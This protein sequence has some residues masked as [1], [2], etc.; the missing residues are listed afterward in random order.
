MAGMRQRSGRWPR[1]RL[2]TTASLVVLLGWAAAACAGDGDGDDTAAGG[3]DTGGGS[4]EST[5]TPAP[6]D[7]DVVGEQADGPADTSIDLRMTEYA[8]T[9][10]PAVAPAGPVELVAANE[11]RIWH[12]LIVVRYD[13]DPGSIPLDAYGA[14]DEAQLGEDA[15]VGKILEFLAGTTCRA[16]FDLAPGEYALICNLVDDGSNPHYRQGMY[17]SITVS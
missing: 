6:T 1:C 16:T 10:T 2:V 12:E 7:C 13:G 9:A 3:E 15:V 11:G 8:I 4:S 17:T 14:A 5:A